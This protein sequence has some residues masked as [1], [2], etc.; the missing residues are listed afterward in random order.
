MHYL[1][2]VYSSCPPMLLLKGRIVFPSQNVQGI[3]TLPSMDFCWS[4]VHKLCSVSKLCSMGQWLMRDPPSM[5]VKVF[6]RHRCSLFKREGCMKGS[7]AYKVGRYKT[8]ILPVSFFLRV[9][10]LPIFLQL[11]PYK[12]IN[13][14]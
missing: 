8:S 5:R 13:L 12:Q 7:C 9:L 1:A 4:Y 6:Q 3:C 10:A 2:L 14:S 11:N